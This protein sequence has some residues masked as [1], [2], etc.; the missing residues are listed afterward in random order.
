MAIV[1][2]ASF[3][4]TAPV[5]AQNVAIAAQAGTT[6]LGG[7]V[8]FG[9]TPKVN[10][11]MMYGFVPSEPS[12]S[13]D[14]ID[15]EIGFPSFLL[16]TVDLYPFG[17]FHISAGGLLITN[18]GA[19]DVVGTFEG[20][21]VEIGPTTFTGGANDRLI[22]SFSLKRFQPY[23]GIGIGNP[24]GKKIGI[25]F[26]AGIGF[27]STPVVSLVSAG[28]LTD[29]GGSTLQAD[30]QQEVGDIQDDIPELLKYYPVLSLSISFGF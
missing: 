28:P 3:V 24:V 7:G 17:A 20:R 4:S 14:D 18:D 8:V 22:G 15:F 1:V 27:G 2:V 21:S 5:Q 29:A 26:D 9:L 16:T 12:F 23:L 10:A 13:I 19:L 11:R 6:G 25:N 30:L